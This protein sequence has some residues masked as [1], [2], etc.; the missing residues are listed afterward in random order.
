MSYS[1]LKVQERHPEFV[2][3]GEPSCVRP[4]F[5]QTP[6][7]MQETVQVAAPQA[8]RWFRYPDLDEQ[9]GRPPGK[10][11]QSF[12]GYHSHDDTRPRC[13]HIG[14]DSAGYWCLLVDPQQATAILA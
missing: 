5:E 8:G 14:Q 9:L 6:R 3:T 7:L 12:G 1:T 4:V 13:F 2:V 11:H 10:F